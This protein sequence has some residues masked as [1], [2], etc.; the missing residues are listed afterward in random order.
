MPVIKALLRRKLALLGRIIILA[1][2]GM[3]VFA[4][5]GAP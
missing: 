2:V 1:F 3:A 4:P 5:W